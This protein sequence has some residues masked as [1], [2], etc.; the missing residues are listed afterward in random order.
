MT[1]TDAVADEK[2][3]RLSDHAGTKPPVWYDIAV[4]HHRDTTI[5]TWVRGIETEGARPAIAEALR[6]Q[7]A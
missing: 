4:C 7:V 6:R 3:V 1:N 2:V 5:E